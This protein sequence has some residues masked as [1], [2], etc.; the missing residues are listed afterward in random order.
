MDCL[1]VKYPHL[2]SSINGIRCH[3]RGGR[4]QIIARCLPRGV[5][6]KNRPLS[7]SQYR[8]IPPWPP[9]NR[10]GTAS[11]LTPWQYGTAVCQAI[12]YQPSALDQKF[13]ERPVSGS[14]QNWHFPH[15]AWIYRLVTSSYRNRLAFSNCLYDVCAVLFSQLHL[16]TT[17]GKRAP[18]YKGRPASGGVYLLMPETS[19]SVTWG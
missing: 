3:G 4:L 14:A 17:E 9:T 11:P 6:W 1:P 16:H 19:D 15:N 7:W 5:S 10:P 2:I 18:P 13:G 12:R 8:S